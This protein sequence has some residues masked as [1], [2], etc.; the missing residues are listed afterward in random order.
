[1]KIVIY[2]LAFVFSATL[3]SAAGHDIETAKKAFDQGNAAYKNGDYVSAL[4]FYQTA[5]SNATGDVINYNLANVYFKL[6]KLP[7]SILHYE[8]AL[9]FDPSNPDALHNL[10]LANSKIVDRI[11]ILPNSKLEIW[12]MEF[13]YGIGPDG[14]AVISILLACISVVLLICYFLPISRN[15]RRFGFFV[16]I[17][18]IVLT[19]ISITLAQNSKQYRETSNTAIVF[20]DKVDVKSEPRDQATNVFAL[21]AGTKVKLLDSDEEWYEVKIA[22]GNQGWIKKTDLEKI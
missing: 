20:T 3:S 9:K 10:K 12:W 19:V 21:H 4:S 18:F 13:K 1:M 14:W 6:N 15:L 16:G 7:Q 5:D 17:I 22:S 8:R 2:I 11:K